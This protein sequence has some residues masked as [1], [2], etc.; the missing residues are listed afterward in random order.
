MRDW[1][2]PEQEAEDRRSRRDLKLE[3]WSIGLL[4]AIMILIMLREL[5]S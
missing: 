4:L 5:I 3:G 1:R 2:T